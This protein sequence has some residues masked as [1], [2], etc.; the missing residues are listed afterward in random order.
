MANAFRTLPPVR[1]R[2]ETVNGS[3]DVQCM[4]GVVIYPDEYGQIQIMEQHQTVGQIAALAEGFVRWTIENG[5][6][7][8][9]M[10]SIAKVPTTFQPT[11]LKP[12][13]NPDDMPPHLRGRPKP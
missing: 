1:I 11:E 12:P 6:I 13:T 5:L 9:I 7:G 3:V 10:Q 2:F 4:A 8:P